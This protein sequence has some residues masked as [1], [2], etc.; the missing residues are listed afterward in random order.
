MIRDLGTRRL[1]MLAANSIGPLKFGHEHAGLPFV[2][3]FGST[4]KAG[5]EL[6][7]TLFVKALRPWPGSEIRYAR[8][9]FFL[10]MTSRP[11][12]S[13]VL[14]HCRSHCTSMR[15]PGQGYVEFQ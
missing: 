12:T 7:R 6:V 1:I 13:D 11:L 10:R 8:H 5:N 15:L 3:K 2:R 4:S 9:P 14:D